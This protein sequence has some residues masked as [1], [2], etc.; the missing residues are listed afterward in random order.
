MRVFKIFLISLLVLAVVL[1]GA[2]FVGREVLLGVTSSILSAA[3]K[4]LEGKKYAGRCLERFGTEQDSFTQLRF[5]DE[6]N[7][8]LELV[9]EDFVSQPIVL[10][11]GNLAPFV[12][13]TSLTSGLIFQEDALP[14]YVE[15]SALGRNFSAYVE[16]EKY[17]F[18]LGQRPDLDYSAG[19]ASSCSAFSST[20][21]DLAAESGQGQQSAGATDCPKSCYQRCLARPILLSFNSRPTMQKQKVSLRS[22][23][24]LSL[25]YVFTDSVES[26][27]VGEE[28]KAATQSL[29]QQLQTLLRNTESHRQAALLPLQ[30]TLDFGD[31]QTAVSANLQDT[32]DHVYTCMTATCYYEVQIQAVD[33]SGVPSAENEL[34]RITVEVK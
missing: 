15:F 24:T 26:A 19:P 28:E 21:C 10:E 22:G 14:S 18:T 9:C 16:D 1:A 25:A 13:K 6:K 33:A 7:F 29:Q 3:S 8:Q 23:E 2:F 32:F 5:L 12:K 20:C 27:F 30:V 17:H 4:Q 31:G 34:N 11:T